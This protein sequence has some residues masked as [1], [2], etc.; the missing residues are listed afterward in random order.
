MSHYIAYYDAQVGEGGI[1]HVFVGSPYQ[2]GHGIGSFLAGLFRRALPLIKSGARSIGKE[3][4]RAGVNIMDDVTTHH[5]PFKQ[6][7]RDRAR[8]TSGTLKR[9]AED[10]IDRLMQGSG[11][12]RVIR[13]LKK[14]SKRGRKRK[15]SSSKRASTKKRKVTSKKK[16][17]SQAGKQKKKKKIRSVTDIFGPA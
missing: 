17:K 6:A 9:K 10:K 14:Q 5:V 12:K 15:Q 3:V 13:G 11:Y 2:R 16:K 8:E 7:F 1:D 4:L